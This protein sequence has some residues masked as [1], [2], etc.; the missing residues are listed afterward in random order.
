MGR[1]RVER[2][3]EDLMLLVLPRHGAN[4]PAVGEAQLVLGAITRATRV[5]Q[6]QCNELCD[7]VLSEARVLSELYCRPLR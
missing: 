3:I 7:Q 4:Q 2:A 5:E 6:L 1:E